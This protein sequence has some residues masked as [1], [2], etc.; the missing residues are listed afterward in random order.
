MLFRHSC[1]FT[2]IRKHYLVRNSLLH[3]PLQSKYV[4]NLSVLYSS[5]CAINQ[6]NSLIHQY[7]DHHSSTETRVQHRLPQ[8]KLESRFKLCDLTSVFYL[9]NNLNMET[10]NLV[11]SLRK[12]FK[13]ENVNEIM[14]LHNRMMSS[15]V[16]KTSSGKQFNFPNF[17]HHFQK[18]PSSSFKKSELLDSSIL[19]KVKHVYHNTLNR[20]RF[21]SYHLK[22]GLVL[23]EIELTIFFNLLSLLSLRHCLF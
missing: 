20:L 10:D 1:R 17:E 11:N 6:L 19:S 23:I 3:V 21:C 13:N 7:N 14:G 12:V 16:N 2:S 5:K 9:I 15:S 4:S 18:S 22:V 8:T